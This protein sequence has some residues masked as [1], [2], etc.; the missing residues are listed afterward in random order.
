MLV[1]FEQDLH[2]R[3]TFT[4]NLFIFTRNTIIQFSRQIEF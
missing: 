1:E 2:L 4:V 3:V